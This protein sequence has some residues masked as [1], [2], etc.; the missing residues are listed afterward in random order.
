VVAYYR[1]L[2]YE[3]REVADEDFRDNTVDA[4]EIGAG[5]SAT[6]VYAVILR[7]G[8]EGRIGTVQLR[9]QDPD[10]YQVKEI[11]GNFN[12]WDLEA[13]YYDADPHY[14]LTVLVAQFAE[15]LRH[16]PWAVDTDLSQLHSMAYELQ[17]SLPEDAD[18]IEFINLLG[19]ARQM[20][21]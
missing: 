14:Q 8:I 13:S 1:L 12:T 6:A 21:R 16:S 7:P 17:D 11:N 19:Q 15:T 4:G 3:N 5:H 20:T 9:W 2:G 10:T 18:M